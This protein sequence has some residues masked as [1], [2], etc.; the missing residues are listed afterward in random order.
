V[1]QNLIR[2]M[3]GSRKQSHGKAGSAD[4]S[5]AYSITGN[6]LRD[7]IRLRE[8]RFTPSLVC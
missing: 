8:N 6:A 1:G 7:P 2:A 4:V 5:W 3:P